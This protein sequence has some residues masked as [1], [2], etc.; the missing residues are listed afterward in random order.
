MRRGRHAGAITEAFGATDTWVRETCEGI[1]AMM[2]MISLCCCD[3]RRCDN[4][5]G[6]YCLRLN[7]LPMGPQ[8]VGATHIRPRIARPEWP[9]PASG[10]R[11][12]TLSETPQAQKPEIGLDGRG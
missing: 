1:V 3:C 8:N 12:V 6:E 9:T 7:Y 10:V 2:T 11:V 4:R 5:S